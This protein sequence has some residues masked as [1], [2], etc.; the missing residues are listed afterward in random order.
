MVKVECNQNGTCSGGCRRKAI[1]KVQYGEHLEELYCGY[2]GYH[3][4][5]NASE[6]RTIIDNNDSIIS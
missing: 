1:Y 3:G 2:C 5:R 6:G 4:G